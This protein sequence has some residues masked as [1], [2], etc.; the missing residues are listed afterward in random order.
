MA[1][2]VIGSQ[3]SLYVREMKEEKTPVDTLNVAKPFSLNDISFY[4]IRKL[5]PD[6]NPSCVRIVEKASPRL[7][8]LYIGELVLVRNLMYA[9]NVD[10]LY[11]ED[12]AHMTSES[13]YKQDFLCR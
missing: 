13:S 7:V 5:I 6:R 4:N 9:V 2:H 1:K 8:S 3:K 10:K 12:R 11:P